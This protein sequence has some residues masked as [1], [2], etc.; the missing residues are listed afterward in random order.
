MKSKKHV[1]SKEN[2]GIDWFMFWLW[3]GLIF[4]GITCWIFAT[5]GFVYVVNLFFGG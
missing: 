2:K 4:L 5:I 1:Q 3:L